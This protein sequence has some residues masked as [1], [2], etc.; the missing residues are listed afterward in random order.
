MESALLYNLNCMCGQNTQSYDK[1]IAEMSPIV[2]TR[3]HMCHQ[4]SVMSSHRLDCKE[5]YFILFFNFKYSPQRECNLI[6]SLRLLL[7]IKES[8]CIVV[9]SLT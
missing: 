2:L 9:A 1:N 5:L 4:I 8:T 3:H 7:D 6:Y